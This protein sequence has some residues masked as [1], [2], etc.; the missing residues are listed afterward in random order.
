MNGPKILRERPIAIHPLSYDGEPGLCGHRAE[1]GSVELMRGLSP[2]GFADLE[3][4][5]E[6]GFGNEYSLVEARTEV[7]LD[8]AMIFVPPGLV[9]E[10]AK[11]EIAAELAIDAAK[12]VEIKST[13]DTGRIVVGDEHAISLLDEVGANEQQVARD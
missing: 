3:G 10:I 8:A 9:F 11:L 4:D 1:F 6:I 5:R 13:G 2:N 12:Q 7:H